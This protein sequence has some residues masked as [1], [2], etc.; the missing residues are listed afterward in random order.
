MK[1]KDI[2]A[3]CKRVKAIINT[4]RPTLPILARVKVES[5]AR[6][7][8]MTAYNMETGAGIT[9][10]L[11]DA[12]NQAFATCVQFADLEK[13]IG[14]LKS[15]SLELLPVER[16]ETTH[17][18]VYNAESGRRESSTECQTVIDLAI[19][20]SGLSFTLN[21]RAASD[22]PMLPG[23]DGEIQAS[24]VCQY[25][26]L[27]DELAF[28]LKATSHESPRSFT[29][30]VLFDFRPTENVVLVGTD[31]RRL[32]R[33]LLSPAYDW[34]LGFP[35][36]PMSFILP[37]KALDSL[38]KLN[39]DITDAVELN[40]Y[41]ALLVWKVRDAGL[42]GVTHLLDTPYPEYEKVIPEMTNVFRLDCKPT[43]QALDALSIIAH[44]HDGRDMVVINAN[45]R[46]NL[47][48]K[49]ESTGKA[50][51]DL[52]LTHVQGADEILVALNIDYLTDILKECDSLISMSNAG[53]LEPCR[54]DYPDS[55]RIAVLMPVRLP[56]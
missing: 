34:A 47:S 37:V 33:A 40:F 7:L 9:L 18:S 48:V 27:A 55:D 30:G 49:A 52:P 11:P 36:N 12:C 45:G 35:E 31:G 22:F 13:I 25:G 3:A 44:E 23:P 51:A 42:S 53:D 4:S 26:R 10:N 19:K 8:T 17:D 1:T 15:D 54:F 21:G 2:K 20:S 46:L 56:D 5:D 32:H 16:T 6:N 43:V 38:L 29:A 41:E 24:F 50:N 39:V 28:V 14:K